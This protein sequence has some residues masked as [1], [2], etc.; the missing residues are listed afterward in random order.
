MRTLV[1]IKW[2]FTISSLNFYKKKEMKVLAKLSRSICTLLYTGTEYS[3]LYS[4]QFI[5]PTHENNK[6]KNN[7]QN[8]PFS[9]GVQIHWNS[10]D[11][12]LKRNIVFF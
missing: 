4:I 2:N 12:F 7:S 9:P 1:R 8:T 6:K 5:P 3:T 11:I 10:F